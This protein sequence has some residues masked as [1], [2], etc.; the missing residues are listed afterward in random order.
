MTEIQLSQREQ[1]LETLAQII[2]SWQQ[3]ELEPF[4]TSPSEGIELPIWNKVRWD[5]Q[6]YGSL[7]GGG[8]GDQNTFRA[9]VVLNGVGRYAFVPGSIDGIVT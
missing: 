6:A 3:S 4:L 5:P 2:P 7:G 1:D 9:I 8:Q